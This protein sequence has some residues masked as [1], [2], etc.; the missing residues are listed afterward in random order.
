MTLATALETYRAFSRRSAV[1]EPLP[2]SPTQSQLEQAA[3]AAECYGAAIVDAG[4]LATGELLQ[5]VGQVLAEIAL[6]AEE[7]R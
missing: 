5:E 4:D 6:V 7:V 3:E 2:D 1:L